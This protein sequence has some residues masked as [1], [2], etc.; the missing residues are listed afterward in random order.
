MLKGINTEA[1]ILAPDLIIFLKKSSFFFF[2][3][4]TQILT[5]FQEDM[6]I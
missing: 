2:P 6:E 1:I 5:T 3:S 4:H